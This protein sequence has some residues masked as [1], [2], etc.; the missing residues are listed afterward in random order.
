VIAYVLVGLACFVL[1][2]VALWAYD[3]IAVKRLEKYEAQANLYL[4]QKPEEWDHWED[5]EAWDEP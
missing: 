1:G 5:A 2:I 3:R 4:R